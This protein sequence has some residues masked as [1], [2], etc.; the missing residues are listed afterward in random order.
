MFQI[1]DIRRTGWQ[2]PELLNDDASY[3]VDL[4]SLGCVIYFCL[5]HGGH[6]FG[7]DEHERIANIAKDEKNFLLLE[8]DTNVE[9]HDLIDRL[10]D[11]DPKKR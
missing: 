1:L 10:L 6:P 5:T 9:A 3:A 8:K 7:N 4:F 11:H 2:A